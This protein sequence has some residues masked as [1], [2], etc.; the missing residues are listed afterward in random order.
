MEGWKDGR[1]ERWQRN[2]PRASIIDSSTLPIFHP[3][4]LPSR[5]RG[6]LIRASCL[7]C[8]VALGCSN[9][10]G[11]A[12]P[13][14]QTPTCE[15]TQEP[16]A[17]GLQT[18]DPGFQTQDSG[19]PPDLST[20]K[21]GSDWPRFLG[22]TG[23]GVSSE[24]GILSPWPKEGLRVV[25]HGELGT[26]Y[27]PPAISRGRLFQ[28]DRA[29][30][31]ARLRCFKSET[32]EPLWT[33]EHASD[34]E[35]SYQYDN[36]PRCGPVVDD[37]LV[38]VLGADGLLHCVRAEDGKLVW[39]VD[40]KA[41]FGVVPNFF[42]V[43]AAPLVEGDLLLMQVGGSPPGS[44]RF[45]SED[46]K[47]NGTGVVAFD[48]RTGKVRYK[49]TDELASYASASTATINGRRWGFVL[50]RGGLIG[51]EPATGKVDFHY[52]WRARELESVNAANPVVV[53]DRVF[54][55]ETYGPGS[56]LLK[57]KPGGY[58]LLWTDAD[59]GRN[60]S[61]QA[62]WST[63]I[64]HEG[65]LYG[66]SG[67]HS[68][69]ADL[70]CIE[71]ATGKLMWRRPGLGLASFLMVD[72]HFVV[73]GEYGELVLLKVNPNKLEVVSIM[74]TVRERP[75]DVKSRPLLEYPCWAAPV[76]SHGLLYVRGKERLVCLELIPD[77]R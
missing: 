53:G 56:S 12:N 31:K 4:N 28:F 55:S 3:S 77:K 24:R 21:T 75:A 27:G 73:L 47:G 40:T 51:F 15:Q 70:R 7:F 5:H 34:Y 72:G 52:P 26:G 8:L 17:S 43:G 61:M 37:D 25:W 39:K 30:D 36:G 46:Q 54:I 49:I 11:E 32:G 20:R 10:A 48:K 35:D 64:H 74:E 2:A 45:P 22:P 76:L 29:G 58:D 23:D 13:P 59:R 67:R 41:D 50:A 62:H 63:P 38:F 66:C 18:P 6:G 33:F 16:S 60:K 1:F 42:G 14:E 69:T 68:G 65:Y 9:Q 19:L 44:G 71:L 57:V